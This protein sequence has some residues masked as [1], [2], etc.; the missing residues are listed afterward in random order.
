MAGASP[1]VDDQPSCPSSIERRTRYCVS[2]RRA[3]KPPATSRSSTRNRLETLLKKPIEPAPHPIDLRTLLFA[4]VNQT[5]RNDKHSGGGN[6]SNP[7]Q[8]QQQRVERFHGTTT[9]RWKQSQHRQAC[10]E[11]RLSPTQWAQWIE[12]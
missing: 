12:K 7:K 11:S 2:A 3:R 5:K 4:S 8:A 10:V 1:N 9:E 6:H